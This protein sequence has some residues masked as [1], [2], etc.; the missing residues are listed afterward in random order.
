MI[1]GKKHISRLSTYRKSLL[2]FKQLGF[3]KVFSDLLG[4]SVGV[5]AAQIRKDFSLF[6]LTGNKRGGYHIDTLIESLNR[7]LL[8][9]ET[10]AIILAGAGHIGTALMNYQ[11]FI[12]EGIRIAAAFDIDPV[13][14]NPRSKIP[15]LPFS[16][17]KTF[18]RGKNIQ[19]GIIAVPEISAQDVLNQMIEAG[20]SGIL[21]FTP[22]FLKDADNVIVNNVYLQFELENLIYFVRQKHF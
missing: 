18:V 13:K 16:D 4:E 14:I 6:G 1:A 8:K 9:N 11:G 20:I 15:V 7:I 10:H 21:N 3:E 2:Q 5:T 19:I 22:I 12:K 17:M